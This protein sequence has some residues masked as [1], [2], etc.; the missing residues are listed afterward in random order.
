MDDTAK[1]LE[2]TLNFCGQKWCWQ[3]H[4]D[5]DDETTAPGG[6]TV[7]KQL[8]EHIGVAVENLLQGGSCTL[9]GVRCAVER[10]TECLGACRGRPRVNIASEGRN[11]TLAQAASPE[12]IRAAIAHHLAQSQKPSQ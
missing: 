9:D 6:E 10:S 11:L 3:D 12:E 7:V 2:V 5:L 8:A 1:S 4:H